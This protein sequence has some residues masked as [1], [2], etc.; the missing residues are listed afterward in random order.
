MATAVRPLAQ[1][2]G[3]APGPC[4]VRAAVPRRE[5]I[6][7]RAAAA[8]AAV[9]LAL[10]PGCGGDERQD[11][12]EDDAT[13]PVEVVRASFPRHQR[14]AERND[15]T[16]TVRNVGDRT[17]PNLAVTIAT[18]GGGTEIEA[19]GRL[20]DEAGLSSRS[21]PVWIVDEGPG[22]TAY[23]NTWALGPLRVNRTATFT[24]RVSAVRAGRHALTYRLAGSLTGRSQLRRE[25]GTIPRGRFDVVVDRRPAKVRVTADGRVIS[26]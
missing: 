11:A 12:G 10:A 26:G 8:T 23:A 2:A 4:Y 20:A 18:P 16:L 25:N 3:R 6:L 24:W 19:F 1:P 15:L 22:D 13:F 9:A 14:L 7:R 5:A 21:R 17:I